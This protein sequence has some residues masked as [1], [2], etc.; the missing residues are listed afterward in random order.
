MAKVS[1]VHA[2]AINKL[3]L[4]LI[5][6]VGLFASD[7]EDIGMFKMY[8]GDV[9][10]NAKALD[11]FN[12]TFD[13]EQLHERIMYQDTLPREHFYKVLKYI[14]NKKLIPEGQYVCS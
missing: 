8:A 5:A 11:E 10:Y 13:A 14:E 12:A 1:K 6:T 7:E 9:A 4:P 3:M 2:V